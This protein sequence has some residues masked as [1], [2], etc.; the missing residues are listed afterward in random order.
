MITGNDNINE[1]RKKSYCYKGD[2]IMIKNF[3]NA[4]DL[5]KINIAI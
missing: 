4:K 1:N 3:E 5:K 2:L